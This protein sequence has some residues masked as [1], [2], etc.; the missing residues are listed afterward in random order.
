MDGLIALSAAR[1]MKK[2]NQPT[3]LLHLLQM[4]N[5]F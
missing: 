3:W 1:Q 2:S 5:V 4:F